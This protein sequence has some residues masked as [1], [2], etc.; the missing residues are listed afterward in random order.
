MKISDVFPTLEIDGAFFNEFDSTYGL[1]PFQLGLGYYNH[2]G[3]KSVSKLVRKYTEDGV[4]TP[5]GQSVIGLMLN[6]Y[7]SRNWDRIWAAY[8][9]EYDPLSN[10]DMTE[11]STDVKG[12]QEN[13]NEYGNKITT[14]VIGETETTNAF[15]A[16]TDTNQYGEKTTT[17]TY[18]ATT[19]TN[20]HGAKSN[21]D[22]IGGSTVTT[23]YGA[24][25]ESE[26][27]GGRSDSVTGST[28]GST[29]H[30][31]Q[32]KTTENTVAAFNSVSYENNSKIE[33]D[34][35]SYTDSET[36]SSSTYNNI[37]SQT[38]SKTST[39][40]TDQVTESSKT[41]GHSEASYTDTMSSDQHVDSSKEA[42]HTDTLSKAAHT[43]TVTIDEHT[44][45]LTE[46]AK[47]DTLTEGSR[48]DTHTLTRTGNIGVTTSQQM[49]ESE[50]ALRKYDFY[51][52]IYEDIDSLL[53]LKVYC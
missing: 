37:G 7:F 25:S 29:T 10:Y 51:K 35:D 18:G 6:D 39:L 53:T 5:A 30:G 40:H 4:I 42:T 19:D 43:D 20:V 17:D 22:T 33:E 44:D 23:E 3:D 49:L 9:A 27:L 48:T 52:N 21:T 15:G 12:E 47:S 36:G 1:T 38:N 14:N 8:Q 24:T 26:V 2:S 45:T 28:T 13:L 34:I 32:N 50:L 46:G 16:T 11:E 31:N 41:N